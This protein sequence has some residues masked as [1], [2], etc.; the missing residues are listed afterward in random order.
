MRNYSITCDNCEKELEKVYEKNRKIIMELRY[1]ISQILEEVDTGDY[2]DI[3]CMMS[4]INKKISDEICS[5]Q[6]EYKK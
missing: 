3:M 6:E 4:D 1:Q 2:C 5:V